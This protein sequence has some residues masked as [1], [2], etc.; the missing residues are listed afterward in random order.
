MHYNSGQ[1]IESMCT[2]AVYN[3]KRPVFE[4]STFFSP[5]PRRGSTRSFDD[6]T[7][8]IGKTMNVALIRWWQSLLHFFFKLRIFHIGRT[9]VFAH[10]MHIIQEKKKFSFWSQ[11]FFF[12]FFLSQQYINEVLNFFRRGEKNEARKFSRNIF[13][14][15]KKKINLNFAGTQRK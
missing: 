7:Y 12:F 5:S 4:N 9:P 3:G 10:Y 15:W 14:W 6:D 13:F 2:G 1:K 11:I 8:F